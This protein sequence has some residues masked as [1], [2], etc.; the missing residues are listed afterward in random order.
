M[1]EAKE[2][3]EPQE[4]KLKVEIDW[5]TERIEQLIRDTFPE[6]PNTAVAVAKCES[7]LKPDAIGPTLD[8]G[9]FQVNSPTWHDIAIELGYT[10]YQTDPAQNIAMARYIYEQSNSWQP[11]V[12][13]T[14]DYFQKH[15]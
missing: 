6:T 9:V 10:E 14:G 4:I 12:C 8:Y 3:E 1:A 11:W 5:T 15:L 2:L 7:G 13:F